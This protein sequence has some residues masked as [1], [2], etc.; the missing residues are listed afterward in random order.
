M[1]L[2]LLLLLVC[3]AWSSAAIAAE[4]VRSVAQLNLSRFAGQWY[5]IARLPMYF[6]RQCV[7][8]STAAYTLREDSLIGV[9]NACRTQDGTTDVAEGVARPVAGQPGQLEARFAPD[10]LGWLPF[11][12]TDY[13]VIDLDPGYQWAVIGE[14]RRR[15]LWILSR[16]PAMAPALFARIKQRA[17]AMGYELDTLIVSAPLR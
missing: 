17:V 4:P 10:V 15:Y 2:F 16:T 13:W 8:E 12:W 1:R 6:Q 9:R 7:A 5:E 11:V 14:P 3:I